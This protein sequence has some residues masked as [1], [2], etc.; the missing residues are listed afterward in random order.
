MRLILLLSSALFLAACQ[1]ADVIPPEN[2]RVCDKPDVP[3][4]QVACTMIYDPVCG[5]DAAGTEVGTFGNSCQGCAQEPVMFFRQG[6][7]EDQG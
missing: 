4:E 3:A 2:A 5:L 7:C 1:S 6:R